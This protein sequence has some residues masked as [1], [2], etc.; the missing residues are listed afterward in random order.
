MDLQEASSL[1]KELMRKHGL[2]TNGWSFVWIKAKTIHGICRYSSK[3][4]GLSKPITEKISKKHVKNTILHEI[5]HAL[6]G[7]GH[8]HDSVWRNKALEIGCNGKRCASVSLNGKLSGKYK[9]KCPKCGMIYIA[10]KKTKVGHW[11]RCDN[12][13]FD[14][15]M[16]LVYVQQY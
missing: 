10:H 14:P 11:C 12:R 15:S 16:R 8:G 6:V 13:N 4:I 7:V 3:F 9:A 1:A 5:A 2:T